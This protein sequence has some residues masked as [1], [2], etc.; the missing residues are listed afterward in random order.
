M[1]AQVLNGVDPGAIAVDQTARF[2]LVVNMRSAHAMG[3]VVPQSIL[4]RADRVIE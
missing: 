3:L 1:L 2:K 4:I